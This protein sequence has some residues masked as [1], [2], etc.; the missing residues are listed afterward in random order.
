MSDGER[1]R[2]AVQARKFYATLPG[3]LG[4]AVSDASEVI[5]LELERK[6]RRAKFTEDE[7]GDTPLGGFMRIQS[8][9]HDDEPDPAA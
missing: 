3:K 2:R 9:H 6:K 4:N 8:P 1:L 5:D 7:Q